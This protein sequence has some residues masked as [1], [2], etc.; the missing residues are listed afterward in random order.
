MASGLTIF[1]ESLGFEEADD[2][3]GGHLGIRAIKELR[4]SI[5]Q[6]ARGAHS[7]GSAGHVPGGTEY[8]GEL[9]HGYCVVPPQW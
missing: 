2:F 1:D 3:L 5:P 6:R 8:A 4:R 9:P 7:V